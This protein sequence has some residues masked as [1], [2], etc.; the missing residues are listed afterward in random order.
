MDNYIEETLDLTEGESVRK[1]CPKCGSK[2]TFTARK[3][4]GRIIY[5]CYKLSCDLKGMVSTAMTMEEM[6]SYFRKPLV[7]TY[8]DNNELT[9]FVYPE[10]VVDGATA[11]NGHLRRFVMRWP[12]LNH[13][14]LM[15]DI[16]SKRAVFP[17]YKDSRLI[18]AIGRALDGAIPKWYRY[19]GVASYYKRCIGKPNGVYVIVEDV[20]SAITVAK[21]MPATT[22]FAILG[23]SLTDDHLADISDNASSCLVAL[24]PDALSKSMEFSKKIQLWTDLPAWVMNVEDD[25]KYEREKD[26]TNLRSLIDGA[27]E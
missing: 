6:E 12:I 4:D 19:S 20:I 22:G 7:E 9:T 27:I 1:A 15:Y 17:I 14:N 2:N 11:Q 5:N 21:R 13:E 23:T 10:H 8:N 24:D 18:D 25:I 16:K 26:M 3:V